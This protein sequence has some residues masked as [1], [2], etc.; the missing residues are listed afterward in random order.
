MSNVR[1]LE[2]FGTVGRVGSASGCFVRDIPLCLEDV[3]VACHSRNTETRQ[4]SLLLPGEG[5]PKSG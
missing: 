4:T 2:S 5:V 1:I 3:V